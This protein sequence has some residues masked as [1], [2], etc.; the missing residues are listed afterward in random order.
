ME[1][2]LIIGEALADPRFCR[3]SNVC[4][5]REVRVMSLM[6]GRGESRQLGFV[7]SQAHISNPLVAKRTTASNDPPIE[8]FL[9]FA[10]QRKG[11]S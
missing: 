2:G 11:E 9:N 6:L 4:A 7:W 5:E 3:N 1:F 8:G 10:V